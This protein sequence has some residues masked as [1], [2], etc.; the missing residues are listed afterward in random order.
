MI[1][2]PDARAQTHGPHA[3][4]TVGGIAD[5][6]AVRPSSWRGTLVSVIDRPV[7]QRSILSGWSYVWQFTTGVRAVDYEATTAYSRVALARDDNGDS[8]TRFDLP[9][10]R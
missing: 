10:G 7:R 4:H 5:A 9:E 8:S 2:L 3:S 1:R 6:C